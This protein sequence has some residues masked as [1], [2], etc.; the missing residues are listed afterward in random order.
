MIMIIRIIIVVGR[1]AVTGV[2]YWD[3]QSRKFTPEAMSA[4]II[5]ISQ[6]TLGGKHR[7]SSPEAAKII[8]MRIGRTCNIP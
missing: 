1:L 3:W 2:G 6:K 5:D 7:R 8:S 4:N